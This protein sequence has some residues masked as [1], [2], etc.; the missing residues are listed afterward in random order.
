MT[1]VGE[2][3]GKGDAPTLREVLPASLPLCAELILLMK[4]VGLLVA[5][6]LEESCLKGEGSEDGCLVGEGDGVRFVKLDT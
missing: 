3:A 2:S 5:V 4:G 1:P 6:V